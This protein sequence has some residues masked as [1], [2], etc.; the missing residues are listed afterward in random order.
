MKDKRRTKR[1]PRPTR[2]KKGQTAEIFLYTSP[3]VYIYQQYISKWLEYR[4][5][6]I[7]FYFIFR[8]PTW[9]E[10]RSPSNR[11]TVLLIVDQKHTYFSSIQSTLPTGIH[12]FVPLCSTFLHIG[13]E[14]NRRKKQQLAFLYLVI[15]VVG[16]TPNNIVTLRNRRPPIRKTSGHILCRGKFYK[17]LAEGIFEYVVCMQ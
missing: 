3:W 2:K 7:L 11:D 4:E 6:V 1:W 15:L 9:C 10:T 5:P 8:W 17:P 16:T 14:Q 13:P 12:Q